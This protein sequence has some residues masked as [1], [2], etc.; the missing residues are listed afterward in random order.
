[1]K[2]QKLAIAAVVST[3]FLWLID[4]LWYVVLMADK[5]TPIPNARP[6]PDMMILVLSY[7]IFSVAFVYIY[8][9]GAEEGTKVSQGMKYGI[10]VTLLVSLSM[11]L[12]WYSL[13]T[14]PPLSQH[15]TEAV[16]GLV[17]YIILGILVAYLTGIPG[18]TR[19][20][21]GGTG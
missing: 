18:G 20:G 14:S 6:M 12:M 11:G 1:M 13:T 9:K 3:V 7:L 8:G 4:Y 17:K 10:W 21:K 5:M 19:D 16:Y 15:L 2:I